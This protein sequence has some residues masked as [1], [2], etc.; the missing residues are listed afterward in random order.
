MPHH[1]HATG[2]IPNIRSNFAARSRYPNHL[3]CHHGPVGAFGG[4]LVGSG[5][6]VRN[7]GDNQDWDI[8]KRRDF[9]NAALIALTARRHG[10]T[11][12][13]PM[14]RISSC[15]ARSCEFHPPCSVKTPWR[16]V[17]AEKSIPACSRLCPHCAVEWLRNEKGPLFVSL[18]NCFSPLV[19]F[20]GFEHGGNALLLKLQS[21]ACRK[22]CP[23]R[24]HG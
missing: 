4:R 20:C 2:I 8:H 3:F 19:Q 5:R 23:L 22:G 16:R 9:Q 18:D 7:I 17:L 24:K 1:F 15:F 21:F 14:M 11:W 13:R 12:L 6:L 10:A